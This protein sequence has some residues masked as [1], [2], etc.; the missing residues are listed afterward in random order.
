MGLNDLDPR[1]VKICCTLTV[2]GCLLFVILFPMSFSYVSYDEYAFK[3]NSITH[4]LDF[5]ETYEMG[6]YF[7]GVGQSPMTFPRNYVFVDFGGQHELSVFDNKGLEIILKSSFEYRILKDKMTELYKEY[8]LGYED[9]IINKARSLIKNAVSEKY[10]VEDYF[11]KRQEVTKFINEVLTRE[12]VNL[13]VEVP[14]GKFQLRDVVLPSGTKQRYEEIAI[15][16]QRNEMKKYQEE[17]S[18]VRAQTEMQLVN[19]TKQTVSITRSAQAEVGA[20]HA[21]AEAQA[22]NIRQKAIAEGYAKIFSELG[23]TDGKDKMEI[24]KLLAVHSGTRY[25]VGAANEV[26]LNLT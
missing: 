11:Q 16:T 3:R 13:Y 15:L 21:E 8:G 6:R 5:S 22:F 9:Q 18:K 20:I 17:S 23:I 7:W 2:V 10:N 4:T 26:V 1:V 25:I 14:P 12:L 24:V 19:I